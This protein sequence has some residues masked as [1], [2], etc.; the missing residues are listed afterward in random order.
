MLPLAIWLLDASGAGDV[1]M[2][3]KRIDDAVTVQGKEMKSLTGKPISKFRLLVWKEGKF[4]P[5]PYQIDERL[6]SGDWVFPIANPPEKDVDSGMLD[7]NDEL[8][9][10]AR[11]AG[12]EAPGGSKPP[13][14]KMG[15]CI[16]VRDPVDGATGYAY[17]FAFDDPPEPS[18]VDYTTYKVDKDWMWMI[19]QTY[20]IGT[21]IE[22]SYFDKIILKRPDGSWSPDIADRYKARGLGIPIP[23]MSTIPESNAK[24]KAIG[25]IDGP[26]RVIRKSIGWLKIAWKIKFQSEGSS[27]NIYY[28]SYFIIPLKIKVPSLPNAMLHN[29]RMV[30]TVDFNRQF[31]GSNYY[32][33]VNTAGVKLDG[34]MSDAEKKLDLNTNRRWYCVTGPVGTVFVRYI[35]SP[36]MDKIVSTPGYYVDDT[37]QPDPPE[38]EPGQSN[39]GLVFK[40]FAQL[41]PGNY[42]YNAYFYFPVNFKWGDQKRILDIV[43][44][45]LS[46]KVDSI[47]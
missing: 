21:G 11:D 34:K 16:S 35:L 20:K 38:E 22:E 44:H 33:A 30:I 32:D 8:A 25:W 1:K 9:F 12:D 15:V 42:S 17:L 46:V 24:A 36:A 37:T 45:P 3:I 47:Q 26:V 10:L 29:F 6:P 18:R 41:P 39:V 4:V 2:T 7:D 14:A 13:G 27:Q 28:P 23:G 43:D 5:A 40:N 31:W 19:G